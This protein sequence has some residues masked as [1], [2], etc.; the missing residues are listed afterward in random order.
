MPIDLWI[1]NISNSAY[2]EV[3]FHMVYL[4]IFIV[5]IF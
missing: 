4:F 1:F 5:I 2:L 3:L